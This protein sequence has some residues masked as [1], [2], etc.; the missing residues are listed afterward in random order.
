[1]WLDDWQQ[2]KDA[3]QKIHTLAKQDD[4]EAVSTNGDKFE[5]DLRF[6]FSETLTQVSD[7]D[8]ALVKEEGDH[9]ISSIMSILK[10]AK[11]KR[12]ILKNE[13]SRLARGNRGISA[14]KNIPA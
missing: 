5:R 8:K 1:M 10:V 11:E 9:L 7:A 13:V 4:W 6:F 3:A 12:G 14:Y 2:L